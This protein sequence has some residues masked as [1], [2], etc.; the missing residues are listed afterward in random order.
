MKVSCILV[1]YNRPTWVR[2]ALASVAEQTYENYEL[3]VVDE[4]DLFDM[5]EVLKEF[6]F[7]SVI[8]IRQLVTPSQRR[9]INRLSVNINE[10]IRAASGDLFCYL[11]DD[12]FLLPGWF[13][14]GAKFF[15][16]HPAMANGYGRLY[17]TK[18]KGRDYDP[19]GKCRY[20]PSPV[21]Q[22]SSVL[23]HNQVMHRRPNPMVWWPEELQHL[24]GPDGAYFKR[25]LKQG[26]FHRMQIDAAVKRFHSKNL[27]QHIKGYHEG[28]LKPDRE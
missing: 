1:S 7:Q 17:Y 3:I 27:Q 26:P 25:L 28:T 4:S 12:D 5:E 9:E 10:G 11:A 24:S 23:D 21:R 15:S 6:A 20:P 18:S 8:F 2:Q 19:K 14:Q 16:S 22:P 13:G